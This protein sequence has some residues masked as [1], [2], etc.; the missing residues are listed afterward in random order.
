MTHPWD[1]V[2]PDAAKPQV[3]AVVT[4]ARLLRP[5]NITD[6]AGRPGRECPGPA[7]DISRVLWGS[8]HLIHG[9]CSY[10]KE[11]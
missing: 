3:A 11:S 4:V 9:H 8:G 2:I 5:P 10:S 1:V 6:V 7:G